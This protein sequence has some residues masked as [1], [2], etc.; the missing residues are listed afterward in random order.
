MIAEENLDDVVPYSTSLSTESPLLRKRCFAELSDSNPANLPEPRKRLR[1]TPGIS[2]MTQ[3]CISN[4]RSLES[5]ENQISDD[6]TSTLLTI[7]PTSNLQSPDTVWNLDVG[8]YDWTSFPYLHLMVN[9]DASTN[10]ELPTT[11]DNQD[12]LASPEDWLRSYFPVDNVDSLESPGSS[13]RVQRVPTGSIPGQAE[14]LVVNQLLNQN[15]VSSNMPQVLENIPL[16]H[17]E[18]M[19]KYESLGGLWDLPSGLLSELDH[20]P[21]DFPQSFLSDYSTL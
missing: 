11:G 20:F 3:V 7:S 9:P 15:D 10:Y 13:N 2:E 21:L 12:A 19:S 8:V 14:G 16:T 6:L 5:P 1:A 18:T 17:L 4:E